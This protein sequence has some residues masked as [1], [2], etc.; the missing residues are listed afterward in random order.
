MPLLIS[1]RFLKSLGA[2][3]DL[4]ANTVVFKQA[5]VT[6]DIHER[7]DGSYQLNLLEIDGPMPSSSPEVDVL[8]AIG[9]ESETES[10]AGEITFPFADE[11]V[12][13]PDE[14]IEMIKVTS[15]AQPS[16]AESNETESCG[17]PMVRMPT[18]R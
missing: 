5:N 3:I 13:S 8:E 14:E 16:G 10:S 6:T 1:K 17:A 4:E 15:G 12:T 11:K 9:E 18:S 7:K 2:Q